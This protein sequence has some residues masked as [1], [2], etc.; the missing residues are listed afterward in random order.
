MPPFSPFYI[1]PQ[2]AIRY[3]P[4]STSEGVTHPEST[5]PRRSEIWPFGATTV[6]P[7][8]GP[9]PKGAFFDDQHKKWREQGSFSDVFKTSH[10]Y[11]AILEARMQQEAKGAWKPPIGTPGS[12]LARPKTLSDSVPLYLS[13]D[14]QPLTRTQSSRFPE[15][16]P[17][18]RMEDGTSFHPH[19]VLSQSTFFFHLLSSISLT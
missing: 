14:A 10:K 15:P 11:M 13:G 19:D 7:Q 9:D 3:V 12:N 2:S 5:V 6:I 16:A 4:R 8:K 17:W 1:H 18:P